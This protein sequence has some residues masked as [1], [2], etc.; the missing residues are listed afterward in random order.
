MSETNP[1]IQGSLHVPFVFEEPLPGSYDLVYSWSLRWVPI[2]ASPEEIPHRDGETNVL[3]VLRKLRP[4]SIKDPFRSH[5]VALPFEREPPSEDL[6]SQHREGKDVCGFRF[7][8][9]RTMRRFDSFWSKPSHVHNGGL[10][11]CKP[12]AGVDEG[13]PVVGQPNM[14]RPVDEDARLWRR[15]YELKLI[16]DQQDEM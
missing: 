13:K 4:N 16:D 1:I 7:H 10:C 8:G 11:C 2:P 9:G 12:D 5:R 3:S 6:D 14:A 15:D